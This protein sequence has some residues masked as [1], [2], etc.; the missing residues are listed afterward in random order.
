MSIQT[1]DI[2]REAALLAHI[3]TLTHTIAEKNEELRRADRTIEILQQMLFGSSTERVKPDDSK[4]GRLFNEAETEADAQPVEPV[5]GTPRE[6][7]KRTKK[8]GS[9]RRRPSGDLE[10]VEIIH[11]LDTEACACP[12]CASPRPKIGEERTEEYEM[13]PAK[14]IVKVHVRAKCIFQS[15]PATDSGR[16]LPGL[17]QGFRP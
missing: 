11:D 4:Q 5:K 13:I 16:N 17:S 7:V 10:R 3:D 2:S 12:W 1:V 14:V 15:K 8:Q 6:P 9:G